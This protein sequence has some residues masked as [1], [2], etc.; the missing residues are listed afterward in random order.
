M[1]KNFVFKKISKTEIPKSLKLRRYQE[2]EVNTS[3][4]A[5]HYDVTAK[6]AR[7]CTKVSKMASS[8]LA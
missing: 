7:K 8:P 3:D 1:L 2:G 5:D 6:E 4:L